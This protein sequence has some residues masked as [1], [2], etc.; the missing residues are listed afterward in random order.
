MAKSC[1]RH[2]RRSLALE[3]LYYIYTEMC[4]ASQHFYFENNTWVLPHIGHSTLERKSVCAEVSLSKLKNL[5]CKYGRYT[6]ILK[7]KSHQS[8]YINNPLFSSHRVNTK[9]Y[10]KNMGADLLMGWMEEYGKK[11][12]KMG[13]VFF[14]NICK[15][16]WPERGKE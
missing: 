11:R 14:I 1:E 7:P 12:V 4:R 15:R 16:D 2:T 8:K 3:M 5:S 6:D 13:K 9:I 10:I